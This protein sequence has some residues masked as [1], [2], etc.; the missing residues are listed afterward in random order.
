MTK[1][2]DED[3]GEK[4]FLFMP[5]D[6]NVCFYL[7]RSKAERRMEEIIDSF[8]RRENAFSSFDSARFH[9]L[10]YCKPVPKTRRNWRLGDAKSRLSEA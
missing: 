10:L 2:D 8:A 7:S 9:F 3:G 6:D 4:K 5:A 1:E